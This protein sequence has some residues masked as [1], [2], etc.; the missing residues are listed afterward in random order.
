MRTITALLVGLALVSTASAQYTLIDDMQGM[1]AGTSIHGQGGWQV[2]R[3]SSAIG[4]TGYCLAVDI[5]GGDIV[6]DL[7]N[8]DAD[9]GIDT[10]FMAYELPVPLTDKA[11]LKLTFRSTGWTDTIMGTNDLGPGW[12]DLDGDGNIDDGGQATGNYAAQGAMVVL[13]TD[14]PFKAR[15]GGGYYEVAGIGTSADT[16]YDLYMMIDS[17]ADTT[18]YWMAPAGGTPQFI[19]SPDDATWGHRN[20]SYTQASNLKFLF[21]GGAWPPP[22]GGWTEE[23]HVQID[24]IMYMEGFDPNVPEPATMGLLALGGLA[25]IRRR[26]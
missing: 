6:A 17:N 20:T 19:A 21:G 12:T 8:I 13:K 16:W 26:R 3:N 23:I 4:D 5:G 2:Q 9:G 24:D 14:A 1:V 25:L 10:V 7:V 11:T 22:E 15:D 18:L